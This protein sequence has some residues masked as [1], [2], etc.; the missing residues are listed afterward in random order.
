MRKD[1]PSQYMRN[2]EY[3]VFDKRKSFPHRH[4]ISSEFFLFLTVIYL[5]AQLTAQLKYLAHCPG[6]LY[7]AGTAAQPGNLPCQPPAGPVQ[8]PRRLAQRRRPPCQY[9]ILAVPAGL[10]P[11]SLPGPMT[12]Q[13]PP[14]TTPATPVKCILYPT[15]SQNTVRGCGEFVLIV[16]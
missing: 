5:P 11:P 12:S 4:P 6:R 15:C 3:L 2:V 13:S 9:G 7:R 8:P 10:T 16:G 14:T 1:F